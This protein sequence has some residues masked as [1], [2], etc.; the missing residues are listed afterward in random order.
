M[1]ESLEFLDVALEHIYSLM[2]DEYL[3]E[4]AEEEYFQTLKEDLVWYNHARQMGWE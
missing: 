4:K 1:K 2:G 3:R